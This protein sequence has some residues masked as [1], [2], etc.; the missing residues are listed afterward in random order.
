[1]KPTAPTSNSDTKTSDALHDALSRALAG[2]GNTESVAPV[3]PVVPKAEPSKPVLAAPVEPKNAPRPP[4]STV[5]APET[6]PSKPTSFGGM[7]DKDRSDDSFRQPENESDFWHFLTRPDPVAVGAFRTDGSGSTLEQKDTQVASKLEAFDAAHDARNTPYAAWKKEADEE[8]EA[9]RR[10]LGMPA[11]DETVPM[12][13]LNDHYG[14]DLSKLEEYMTLHGVEEESRRRYGVSYDQLK[15]RLEKDQI[16]NPDLVISKMFEESHDKAMR[17]IGTAFAGKRH[18]SAFVVDDSKLMKDIGDS[19]NTHF[20]AGLSPMEIKAIAAP[21]EY[22]VMT[23]TGPNQSLT[24][25]EIKGEHWGDWLQRVVFDAPTAVI[26]ARIQ[27]ANKGPFKNVLSFASQGEWKKAWDA[28]VDG[29]AALTGNHTDTPEEREAYIRRIRSN[30]QMAEMMAS[31]WKSLMEAAGEAGGA[32]PETTEKMG[33]AGTVVGTLF[34]LDALLAVPDTFTIGLSG[35]SAAVKEGVHLAR[36]RRA[37]YAIKTF[38]RVAEETNDVKIAS[39]TLRKIDPAL[40]DVVD[41]SMRSAVRS[42]GTTSAA[43]GRLRGEARAQLTEAKAIEEKLASGELDKGLTELVDEQAFKASHAKASAETAEKTARAEHLSS[44][45]EALAAKAAAKKAAAE[46]ALKEAELIESKAAHEAAVAKLRDFKASTSAQKTAILA[47]HTKAG[48]TTE[49]YAAARKA[50]DD[51]YAA[52]RGVIDE[53]APHMVRL[54]ELPAEIAA[55]E[56]ARDATKAGRQIGSDAMSTL[57]EKHG[58]QAYQ[59]YKK[60]A[61]ALRQLWMDGKL[62]ME[63]YYA[64]LSKLPTPIDGLPK[65]VRAEYDTL[66]E[67]MRDIYMRYEKHVAKV[68]ALKTELATVT[69]TVNDNKAGK[70]AWTELMRQQAKA[71]SLFTKADQLAMSVGGPDV[72]EDLLKSHAQQLALHEAEAASTAKTYARVAEEFGGVAKAS[73]EADAI[74][75][76]AGKAATEARLGRAKLVTGNADDA[77]RLAEKQSAARGKKTTEVFTKKAELAQKVADKT[78]TSEKLTEQSDAWKKAGRETLR[79]YEAGLKASRRLAAKSRAIRES[80]E[81]ITSDLGIEHVAADKPVHIDKLKLLRKIEDAAGPGGVRVLASSET[82]L[83]AIVKKMVES[84]HTVVELSPEELSQVQRGAKEIAGA[85]VRGSDDYGKVLTH[86]TVENLRSIEHTK[87]MPWSLEGIKRRILTFPARMT[88]VFGPAYIKV[89][90]VEEVMPDIIRAA[91]NKTAQANDEL[92]YIKIH[93]QYKHVSEEAKKGLRALGIDP[94]TNQEAAAQAG[95]I[96]DY[97]DRTNPLPYGVGSTLQNTSTLSGNPL[98]WQ[99]RTQV[100]NDSRTLAF[101]EEL[102]NLPEGAD[103][104]KLLAKYGD[105]AAPHLV[106]FARVWFP[107]VTENISPAIAHFI[108]NDTIKMLRKSVEEE[109]TFAQFMVAMKDRVSRAPFVGVTKVVDGEEIASALGGRAHAGVGQ[110]D[111]DMVRVMGFAGSLV[112]HGSNLYETDAMLTKAFGGVI[113]AETMKHVDA[114]L[115]GSFSGVD[116]G[117]VDIKRVMDFFSRLGLPMTADRQIIKDWAGRASERT[118]AAAMLSADPKTPVWGT[119]QL[120]EQLD[121]ELG[122]VVKRLEGRTR[123]DEPGITGDG[124]RA[125]HACINVWRRQVTVGYL[126]PRP[127]FW[128]T[129]WLGNITQAWTTAGPELAIQGGIDSL[130]PNIPVRGKYMQDYMSRMADKAQGKAVIGPVAE[131]LFNPH[132][133]AIANGDKGFFKTSSGM[134]MSYDTARRL[135]VEGG[136]VDSMLREELTTVFS[137]SAKVGYLGTAGRW[138]AAES[139]YHRFFSDFQ[140]MVQQRARMSL[141]VRLISQGHQ[142]EVASKM[143]NEAYFDWKHGA[144]SIGAFMNVLPFWR[145]FYLGHRQAFRA[146]M[147]GVY[148]SEGAFK[149]ALTGQSEMARLRQQRGVIHAIEDTF[150]PDQQGPYATQEDRTLAIAAN[151][152]PLW[153]SGKVKLGMY[154]LNKETRDQILRDQGSEKQYGI[155]SMPDFTTL[156]FIDMQFGLMAAL[157]A[158]IYAGAMGSDAIETTAIASSGEMLSDTIEQGFPWTSSPLHTLF[159]S[160]GLDPED[161]TSSGD[162]WVD[163]AKAKMLEDVCNGIGIDPSNYIY[164]PEDAMGRYKVTRMGS[165]ILQIPGVPDVTDMYARTA[166][167][168]YRLQGDEKGA[169]FVKSFITKS[170]GMGP[171]F[172]SPESRKKELRGTAEHK[173]KGLIAPSEQPKFGGLTPPPLD[174]KEGAE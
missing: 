174:R 27:T 62:S 63:Q 158:E 73:K 173:L 137:R 14:V 79:D 136:I 152:A 15:S 107:S 47:G 102:A 12:L 6:V 106:G 129:N 61:G 4:E 59:D 17:R 69:K 172:Y 28:Y 72:A 128:V 115:S 131:W 108:L 7:A 24:V 105:T 74:L 29:Q 122:S 53:I 20:I 143:V 75:A 155:Y 3:S 147:Q 85:L 66:A 142:P 117:P 94:Q 84:P 46:K 52:N 167:N 77:M 34:G 76:R 144:P 98:W 82:P 50:A 39:D 109:G 91:T 80:Q 44:A 37:Q 49:S 86:S 96:L 30:P 83:G 42:E 120:V 121:S 2:S 110:V 104:E 48:K 146:A 65:E 145:F 23:P 25:R 127:S 5:K 126:I 154:E 97:L 156:G 78:A 38:E 140:T 33:K 130:L 139:G 67:G 26:G 138:L 151:E 60:S 160:I 114:F 16:D 135:M 101:M 58:G 54:E 163:G 64:A 35:A 55:A 124:S 157:G 164:Q 113:D 99:F 149:A 87:A 123:F 112:S 150:M 119:K 32:S 116:G 93:G 168:P 8:K 111:F 31:E 95:L 118:I 51:L 134:V 162:E 21:R 141:W 100:L 170:M 169:E 9:L 1:M 159:N 153:Q 68:D 81:L 13:D 148:D 166:L 56:Q 40:A 70:K 103:I 171:Y 132:T 19:S 133:A 22:T 161:G 10:Q 71:D 43:V 11:G 18:I 165:L 89:G 57:L 125:A 36:L 41:A 92:A 90:A 88:K 45:K